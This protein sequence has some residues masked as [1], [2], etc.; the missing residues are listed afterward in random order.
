MHLLL[1]DLKGLQKELQI[2]IPLLLVAFRF[3]PQI[4]LM[5]QGLMNGTLSFYECRLVVGTLKPYLL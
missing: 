3:L 1:S 2:D 5:W 4:F